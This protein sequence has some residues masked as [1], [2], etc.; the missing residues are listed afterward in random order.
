MVRWGLHLLTPVMGLGLGILRWLGE[1]MAR[2]L[3]NL[4]GFLGQDEWEN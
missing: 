1:L 4:G 3:L 2:A